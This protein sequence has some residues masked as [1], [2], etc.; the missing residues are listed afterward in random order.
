M[1]S[2]L[3]GSDGASEVLTKDYFTEAPD[4]TRVLLRWYHTGHTQAS[5]AVIYVHGGG[6]ILA[7]IEV[8]NNI[9]AKFV[10]ATGVPFLAVDYRLAPEHPYPTPVKDI[11]AGLTW[12]RAHAEELRVDPARIAL[13]GDSGGGGLAAATALWAR[14]VD[15]VPKVAHLILLSPMLDDRTVQ[16]DEHMTQFLT[17]STTDNET[18]WNAVLGAERGKESVSETA[19]PARMTSA[20]GMPPLYIEVGELDLFRDESVAF[21]TKFWAAGISTELHVYPGCCH[22]FDLYSAS[23]SSIATRSFSNYHRVIESIESMGE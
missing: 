23:S 10:A 7:S 20:R 21:A 22:G 5:P 18:G 12:L 16:A 3:G 8:Y 17:W 13:M 6:M 4:G 15:H 9:V 1:I 11:Y 14:S 2:A 19:A